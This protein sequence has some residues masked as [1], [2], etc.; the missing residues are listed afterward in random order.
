MRLDLLLETRR[1]PPGARNELLADRR[2]QIMNTPATKGT[3]LITG[4]SSGI[5]V[6]R[7]ILVWIGKW[8]VRF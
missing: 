4:T 5:G 3:A 6:T 2:D 1:P 7:G 8:P